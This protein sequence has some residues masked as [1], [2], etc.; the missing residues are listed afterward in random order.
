MINTQLYMRYST[1]VHLLKMECEA[2][3]SISGLKTMVKIHHIFFLKSLR[4]QRE[5]IFDTEF[6]LLGNFSK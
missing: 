2:K 4:T 5:V 1:F 3:I 6:V